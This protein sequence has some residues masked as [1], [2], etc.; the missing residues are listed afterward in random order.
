VKQLA[1]SQHTRSSRSELPSSHPERSVS[2]AR[3]VESTVKAYLY[4]RTTSGA[5][6]RHSKKLLEQWRFVSG[7][8]TRSRCPGRERYC[9]GRGRRDCCTVYCCEGR[10]IVGSG[11]VVGRESC[12]NTNRSLRI[13]YSKWIDKP[14]PF[15]LPSSQDAPTRIRE[16]VTQH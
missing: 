2:I 10:L 16:V 5:V 15:D 7:S 9:L 13:I 11:G 14:R 3:R 1:R 4:S 8:G 6:R 12:G